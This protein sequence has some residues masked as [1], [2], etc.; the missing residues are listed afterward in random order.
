MDLINNKYKDIVTDFIGYSNISGEFIL[1]HY[2]NNY[3]KKE[4][5]NIDN[6][7]YYTQYFYSVTDTV[8]NKIHKFTNKAMYTEFFIIPDINNELIAYSANNSSIYSLEKCNFEYYSKDE[9][10][11]E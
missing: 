4:L 10:E 3:N 9:L 1:K 6:E 7:E 8:Y 5:L 2:D 11:Y